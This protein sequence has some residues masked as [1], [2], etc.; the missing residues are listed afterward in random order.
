MASKILNLETDPEPPKRTRCMA[1][2]PSVYEVDGCPRCGG[3][4][5]TWSEYEKHV[6][7]FDCEIDY[8]PEHGGIFDGPIP[9][10]LA[11]MM[12]ISLSRIEI[13]TG[14]VITVE[15]QLREGEQ[16]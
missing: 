10:G 15:E 14:R 12:G 1:Q 16:T 4:N 3:H 13:A 5:T 7:C 8:E 6:W 9:R 2:A 11:E